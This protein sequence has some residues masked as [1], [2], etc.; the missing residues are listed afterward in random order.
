LEAIGAC[1]SR[2]YAFHEVGPVSEFGI[3]QLNFRFVPE[4]DDRFAQRK[5]KFGLGGKT[6]SS[7]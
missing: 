6:A 7:E 1:H 5:R 4:G 3:V 2:R